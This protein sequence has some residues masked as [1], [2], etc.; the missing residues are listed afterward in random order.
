MK[1]PQEKEIPNKNASI[2]QDGTQVRF[3]NKY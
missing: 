2:G 1:N 3:I